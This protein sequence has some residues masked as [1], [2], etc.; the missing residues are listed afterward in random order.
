M[1]EIA[2]AAIGLFITLC[3]AVISLWLL[4]FVLLL[5]AITAGLVTLGAPGLIA[6]AVAIAVGWQSWMIVV[7]I[8]HRWSPSPPSSPPPTAPTRGRLA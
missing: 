5:V 4:P 8:R 2:L 1:I 7:E 6:A 3:L